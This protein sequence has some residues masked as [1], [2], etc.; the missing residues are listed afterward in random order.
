MNLVSKHILLLILLNV[1]CVIPS[2]AKNQCSRLFLESTLSHTDKKSVKEVSELVS[3]L[4]E[5]R[6]TNDTMVPI[7]FSKDADL[8]YFIKFRLAAKLNSGLLNQHQ[9]QN[10]N[11]SFAPEARKRNEDI[12]L[13]YDPGYDAKALIFRPKSSYLNIRNHNKYGYFTDDVIAHYGEVGAVLKSEVKKRSIWSAEDSFDILSRAK[14]K[15]DAGMLKKFGGF[16]EGAILESEG[17]YL[18]ALTFGELKL[19]DIDHLLVLRENMVP[20]LKHL[21]LPIYYLEYERKMGRFIFTKGRQ[22]FNP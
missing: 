22:L 6:D 3:R 7:D 19:T 12:L 2:Y 10:S 13:G 4:K 5:F 8:I 14:N 16:D 21:G 11:G 18:E 1:F 9:T 20:A 17:M 15:S